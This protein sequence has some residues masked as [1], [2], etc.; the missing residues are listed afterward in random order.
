MLW[1]P[2]GI[3][4]YIGGDLHISVAFWYTI[5]RWIETV[6][7]HSGYEITFHPVRLL[8]LPSGA[9]FHDFHHSHFDGNYGATIIWD[10][11]MGTN[12]AYLAYEAA[13]K[14]VQ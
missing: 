6:E 3:V 9:K 1:L 7:A 5:F 8:L 10:K 14:S 12:K 11:L 4:G 13:K 2:L